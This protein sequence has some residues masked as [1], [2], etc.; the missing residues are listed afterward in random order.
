LTLE[1]SERIDGAEVVAD[2]TNAAA[3]GGVDQE[4]ND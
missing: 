4:N 2:A 3:N 1:E